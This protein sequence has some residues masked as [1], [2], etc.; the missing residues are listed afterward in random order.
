MKRL[1]MLSTAIACGV[2]TL[3]TAQ[4]DAPGFIPG[5]RTYSPFPGEDFPNQVFF[6]DTHLHTSYS[7]DAGMTGTTLGP[8]DAYRFAKGETVTSSMGVEAR[9]QRPLDFLVVADHAEGLGIAPMIAR[10]DP[11]VLAND[12]GRQMHDLT[13]AGNGPEAY[14]VWITSKFEGRNTMVTNQEF[15]VGPWEEIINAAEAANQPGAFTAFIGYEWSSMPGGDNLHRVVLYRDGKDLANTRIPLSAELDPDPERL[16]DWMEAYEVETGGKLL[17]IPHNGNVSN[18]LMFDDVTFT[19]KEP[20]SSEYAARRARWEPIYEVTQA[21][22]DGEAH[23]SLSPEDEFADFYTWDKGSFG[24][25]PKTPDMLPREYAREAL[26]RGMAYENALGANP[27]KIG[28][29]GSSD[30]HTALATTAENN[31]FGKVAPLE[32]TADPIRFYEPITGR[33]GDEALQIKAWET[34]AAGLAGVWAR[35]NTREA[36]WDAMMRKEVY[37]TTGTRLKVRVFGGWD[38]SAEDLPRSNFAEHGYDNGVPMGGDLTAAPDGKAPGFVIRAIRDA[39]GANLDRVQIIKGWLNVDGTTSEQIHEV[40][41]S[42]DRSLGADGKL[43]TVGNTVDVENATYEN[44]IG[45]PYLTG[46][47]TDPNFDSSERA[48]YYVRV[49]EIPTPR[50]TTFDA[51]VFG[52]DIPDGAPV[53]IQERAYTSP[54]WYTP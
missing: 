9:L 28:L 43:P 11:I 30:S 27:F 5:E 10:S 3:A 12:V 4:E 53:D 29:I 23:P 47:W 46:F 37:G 24:I 52:V 20:L 48:L 49:L 7:T 16:W 17:A 51:K 45:E 18:G 13:K 54:I 34:A 41:W 36:L 26:K 1:L 14:N 39:D 22:G 35:E 32:P 38:F 15:P 33:L 40:V 31:F 25:N 42:G 21:K 19:T 6:G 44:T 50:W 8:S 2:A